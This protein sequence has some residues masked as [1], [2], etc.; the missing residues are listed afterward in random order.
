MLQQLGGLQEH[1]RELESASQMIIYSHFNDLPREI[2][3][4]RHFYI[5]P[6]WFQSNSTHPKE[7]MSNF[8]YYYLNPLDSLKVCEVSFSIHPTQPLN[9]LRK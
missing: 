4:C 3:I 8:L 5:Q 1:L 7:D 9:I 6:N 2:F